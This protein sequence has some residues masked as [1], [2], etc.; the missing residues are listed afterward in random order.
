MRYFNV[1]GYRQ[2]PNGE[3]AAVIPKFINQIKN[4]KRP[5]INGDGNYSR[6]FTF[7]DNVVNANILAMF[8]TNSECF[9]EVF[10]I[11]ASAATSIIDLFNMIRNKLKSNIEP[12]FHEIRAG[13][14]PHSNADI[15]KANKLLNYFPT[16]SIQEG[17]DKLINYNLDNALLTI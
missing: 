7:I 11:G 8:T 17:L 9:G 13:D 16:V 5:V 2:N 3:Y 15:T 6:D 4:N 10:N 1:F 12:I 14:I